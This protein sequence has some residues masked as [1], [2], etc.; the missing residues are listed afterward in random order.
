MNSQKT[1]LFLED[2]DDADSAPAFTKEVPESTSI[3]M[4]HAPVHIANDGTS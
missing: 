2:T 1:I 4:P 3:M